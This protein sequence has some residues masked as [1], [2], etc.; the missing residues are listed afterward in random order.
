MDIER[1]LMSVH[2]MRGADASYGLMHMAHD[3]KNVHGLVK[4][5]AE[6]VWAR[7]TSIRI[8]ARQPNS[9]PTSRHRRIGTAINSRDNHARPPHCVACMRNGNEL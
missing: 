1:F 3:M 7:F 5:D 9:E 8:T 2:I 6:W 4:I